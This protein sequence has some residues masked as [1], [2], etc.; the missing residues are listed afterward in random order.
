MYRAKDALAS[1]Q[2]PIENA[3]ENNLDRLLCRLD[4]TGEAQRA[5]QHQRERC[6][7]VYVAQMFTSLGTIAIRW[8]KAKR[9]DDRYTS[10]VSATAVTS[11]NG[12]DLPPRQAPEQTGAA[13]RRRRT[14]VWGN[15]SRRAQKTERDEEKPCDVSA[16]THSC[17]FVWAVLG[18]MPYHQTR[19]SGWD[20]TCNQRRARD[21]V[22]H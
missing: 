3:S 11:E 13:P 5:R 9:G 16:E 20:M 17:G 18:R 14:S 7:A 1:V 12:R 22:L 10:N 2:P 8:G 19:R 6:V 4:A 21:C 15:S